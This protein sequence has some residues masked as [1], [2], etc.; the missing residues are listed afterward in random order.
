MMIEVLWFGV[1][2]CHVFFTL[3]FIVFYVALMNF[4]CLLLVFPLRCI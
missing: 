3:P 2:I 4:A 1:V